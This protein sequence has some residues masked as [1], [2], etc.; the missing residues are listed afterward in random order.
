MSKEEIEQ[1]DDG[2]KEIKKDSR[3]KKA[4]FGGKIVQAFPKTWPIG[5]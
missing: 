5:I 4:R 3:S 2:T 1:E